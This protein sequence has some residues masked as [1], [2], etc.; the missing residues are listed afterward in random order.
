MKTWRSMTAWML[1]VCLLVGMIG[2]F[3]IQGA[4]PLTLVV[5]EKN[6]DTTVKLYFSSSAT[7]AAN[8]GAYLY[9]AD[10]ATSPTALTHDGAALV[11][12]GTLSATN[13]TMTGSVDVNGQQVDTIAEIEA[14]V[15]ADGAYAGKSVVFALYETDGTKGD[16]LVN[17]VKAGTVALTATTVASANAYDGVLITLSEPFT[18]KNVYQYND[19]HMMVEFSEAFTKASG[20]EAWVRIVDGNYR[21]QQLNGNNLQGKVVWSG[22]NAAYY[23]KQNTEYAYRMYGTLC[24]ANSAGYLKNKTYSEIK[25]IVDDHNAVNG[26]AKW[27]LKF[28][29]TETTSDSTN[30]RDDGLIN[31][32]K[33]LKG[34]RS[35]VA[36]V[37]TISGQFWDSCFVDITPV[38]E[39]VRVTEAQITSPHTLRV[40]FSEP[41]ATDR[42]VSESMAKPYYGVRIVNA[43]NALQKYNN[44]NMQWA[45][46]LTPTQDPCVYTFTITA[47]Q[48]GI[49]DFNSIADLAKLQNLQMKLCIEQNSGGFGDVVGV[50]DNITSADGVRKLEVS[51][52]STNGNYTQITGVPQDPQPLKMVSA[53]AINDSQIVATFNQ[54]AQVTGSPL[55]FV[56]M[57]KEGDNVVS[58][59]STVLQWG[60]VFEWYNEEHTQVLWTMAGKTLNIS[61]LSDL[62]TYT[63]LEAEKEAG[64]ELKF[65][66]VEQTTGLAC[67]SIE[68]LMVDN[69]WAQDGYELLTGT[70]TSKTGNNGAYI[71]ITLADN[72]DTAP[73]AI[74]SVKQINESQLEV[75][76]SAPVSINNKA[77]FFICMVD[78]NDNVVESP[79]MRWGCNWAYKDEV[80]STVVVTMNRSDNNDLGLRNLSE[81]LSYKK[82]DNYTQ[83]GYK[84]SIVESR[85][86]EVHEL[87]NGIVADVITKGGTKALDAT[88]VA[89]NSNDRVYHPIEWME[90]DASP[91]TMKRAEL[92][93]DTQIAISFSEPIAITGIP[94]SFVR[95]V[96]ANN[97]V[98]T[99]NGNPVQFGGALKFDTQDR[100]KLIY[101]LSGAGNTIKLNSLVDILAFK[102]DLESLKGGGYSWKVCIAERAADGLPVMTNNL[103]ENVSSASR[104]KKM[105]ATVSKTG[106]AEAAY[107]LL[108]WREMP[109]TKLNVKSVVAISDRTAIITFDAPVVIT[110]SPW[111]AMGLVDEKNNLIFKTP[112]GKPSI[113]Q[114]GNSS[115]QW[116]GS[117]KWYN[118]EHTQIIWT[119]D[120][121]NHTGVLN[122]TDVFNYRGLDEFKDYKIKFRIEESGA[123]IAGNDLHISNITLAED[124]R[125]HLEA[126]AAL[127]TD[128]MWTDVTI[129]Y[130]LTHIVSTSR[131]VNDTQIMITFSEPVE[132]TGTPFIALRFVKDGKLMWDGKPD[133]S[134]AMQFSGTWEWASTAHNKILWTMNGGN[135]Y[136]ANNLYEVYNYANGLVR[137]EGAEIAMCVEEAAPAGI[138]ATGI[139]ENISSLDGTRHLVSTE[140]TGNDKIFMTPAGSLPKEELKVEKVVAIDDMTLEITYS[141]PIVFATGDAEPSMAIRYMTES[142]DTHVVTDGKSAIFRG[143]W[144]WKEGTDNVMV[145]TL[146]TTKSRGAESLNDIFQFRGNFKFNKG[147][148]ILFCITDP[149][150]EDNVPFTNRVLGVTNPEGTAH[151]K[152]T[153]IS[154]FG[155]SISE[156]EIQYQL[157]ALEGETATD[158]TPQVVRRPD[159]TV[160]F[161]IS[162]G[163]TAVGLVAMIVLLATKKKENK[164]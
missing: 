15:A 34:N 77:L 39:K 144:K 83:Y 138:G 9:L 150:T 99:L 158:D 45:G 78:A 92:I 95:L 101:T 159:Y 59:G 90:Y 13:W 151:L 141:G 142:G 147:A 12:N 65:S 127:A 111:M 145:W 98:V 68:N 75:T 17:S 24:N 80:Q 128:R 62:L 58:R 4:T 115:M 109:E 2:G 76:F 85:A 88:K 51:A 103:I 57:V 105:D 134:F 161:W 6:S 146:D 20:Y 122:L 136:G 36:N 135:R 110:G 63:G 38:T 133:V 121:K 126:N 67:R 61:N 50:V 108:E 97:N 94:Y 137:F 82:M 35:L 79:K 114:K 87:G 60:G 164:A 27:Y 113:V 132:I 100:S 91:V 162:G 26:N 148:L 16:G 143:N 66:I 40:T 46:A 21:L 43:N 22:T 71:P 154:E 153:K 5:A 102:G 120:R 157:P 70:S 30:V 19:T 37:R 84:L 74:T 33:T 124:D 160:I 139:L 42:F 73:L 10:S 23:G 106:A 152:A 129:D 118:E 149:E 119:M 130:N 53:V 54:P 48:L 116:G 104:N 125:I 112:E 69:Y 1:T 29:L 156:I 86:G 64:Y 107:V 123:G 81:L 7:I 14:L 18:I 163:I 89:A 3:S 25:K 56:R 72:Y 140:P 11:W 28:Y 8:T 47:S 52:P 155:T 117:W 41:I 31:K 96:D 32:F 93:N 131:I 55:M 44:T 49:S